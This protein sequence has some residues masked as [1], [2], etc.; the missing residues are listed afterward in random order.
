VVLLPVSA[1]APEHVHEVPR[2][3]DEPGVPLPPIAEDAH[4]P[5]LEA[6]AS[7]HAQSGARALFLVRVV[8]IVAAAL[9][10]LSLRHDLRYALASANPIDLPGNAS[11]DQ[12]RGASHQYVSIAGIPGGVGAIDYRRAA[13]SGLYRLAPLVDRPEILV[14]LR[15]PNGVDSSRF[16]PPTSVQG[17]LVPIDEAGVRFG[18]ARGLLERATGHGVPAN[19]FLLEAG[20]RPS[21]GAPAVILGGVALLVLAIQSTLLLASRRRAG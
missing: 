11:T 19:A 21:L 1:S 13:P 15:L 3:P 14:E 2:R 5:E 17:R 16:V 20:A 8:S 12:L 9:L 18:D 6:L 7:S 10:A 4:D